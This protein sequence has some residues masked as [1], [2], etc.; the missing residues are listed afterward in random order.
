[1]SAERD[2]A[3]EL[4]SH[5]T[6]LYRP[7]HPT[8]LLLW[9]AAAEITR[10]REA[11]AQSPEDAEWLRDLANNMKIRLSQTSFARLEAIADRLSGVRE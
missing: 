8:A 6:S 11:L 7:D 3:A 1:M 9:E 4:R 5:G 2:I 10:L